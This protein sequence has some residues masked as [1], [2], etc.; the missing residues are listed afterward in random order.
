MD[1]KKYILL[2]AVLL[3]TACGNANEGNNKNE[4]NKNTNEEVEGLD[5]GKPRDVRNDKTGN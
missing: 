4:V 5:L 3:L 2:L 1:M